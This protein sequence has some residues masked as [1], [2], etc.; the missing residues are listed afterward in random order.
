MTVGR[1]VTNTS[2]PS[3]VWQ[4][5]VSSPFPPVVSWVTLPPSK[6]MR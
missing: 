5:W 4:G 6:L 2:C 3:A 1:V